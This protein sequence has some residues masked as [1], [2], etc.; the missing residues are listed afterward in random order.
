MSGAQMKYVLEAFFNCFQ[1]NL[2]FVWWACIVYIE[3][4]GKLTY[5]LCKTFNT[6]YNGSIIAYR[7]GGIVAK[8]FPI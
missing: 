4:T 2:Q 6:Y 1:I 3:A 5:V 7:P 8:C